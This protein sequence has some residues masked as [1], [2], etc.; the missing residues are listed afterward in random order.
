M[1]DE[2]GHSQGPPVRL[3]RLEQSHAA[4]LVD[5][6]QEFLADGD[7]RYADLLAYVGAYFDVVDRFTHDRDLASNR[8]PQDYFLLYA[9]E[10]LVGGVRLR[11]RLIPILRRDGGH[12]G[13]EV[14]PSARNRGHATAMLG[15]TLEHAR[16]RGFARVLLT[17]AENNPASWRVVEKF[18]P[19]RDGSSISPHTQERMRRYWI[20]L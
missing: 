13:Y 18:D 14:R 2:G 6:A 15:L 7:P 1:E 10:V 5:M 20:S 3:V 16:S 9:G 4:D 17:V 11:H 12:I 8:V 19:R